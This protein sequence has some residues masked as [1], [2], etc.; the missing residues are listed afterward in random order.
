MNNGVT[1]GRVTHVFTDRRCVAIVVKQ[2]QIK[3]GDLL[4]YL[5]GDADKDM[6]GSHDSQHMA[7]SIEIDKKTV[8]MV[9]AGQECAIQISVGEL[10]PNNAE[11]IL[12]DRG[13]V[14]EESSPY[15]VG[16]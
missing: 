15:F 10:P 8:T 13:K 7:D 9:E 3:Q 12:L 16:S 5:K 11:V 14:G 6:P 1:I 2:G 4:R